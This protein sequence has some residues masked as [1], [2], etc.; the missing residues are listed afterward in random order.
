MQILSAIGKEELYHILKEK[1]ITNGSFY[2]LLNILDC[3]QGYLTGRIPR[4][5]TGCQ[6]S[7]N[8]PDLAHTIALCLS[9]CVGCAENGTVS[10]LCPP[11]KR[12]RKNGASKLELC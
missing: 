11:K 9:I 12:K 10:I 3:Q 4:W 7:T 5:P 2:Q 6:D 8:R 1:I